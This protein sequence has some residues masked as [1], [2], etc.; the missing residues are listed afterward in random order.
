MNLLVTTNAMYVCIN[1][2][3]LINNLWPFVLVHVSFPNRVVIGI[4]ITLPE[5][6]IRRFYSFTLC[7]SYSTVTYN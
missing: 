1:Y 4:K 5:G 3:Y 2:R 6:R 7:P